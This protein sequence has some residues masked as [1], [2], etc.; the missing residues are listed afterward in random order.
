MRAKSIRLMMES[1]FNDNHGT[2]KRLKAP[3]SSSN[4]LPGSGPRCATRACLQFDG[5]AVAVPAG[6]ILNPATLKH[7][8]FENEVFQHLQ[9][10]SARVIMSVCRMLL[11]QSRW[12]AAP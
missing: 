11:P 5:E 7:V 12:V 6:D 3:P 8:V 9:V 10:S 1:A 4:I 2:K